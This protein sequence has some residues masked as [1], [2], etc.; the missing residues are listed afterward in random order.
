MSVISVSGTD[1]RAPTPTALR[2][3][4]SWDGLLATEALP[5]LQNVPPRIKG[6]VPLRLQAFSIFLA[7][8][9]SEQS[10][11]KMFVSVEAKVGEHL[12]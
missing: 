2:D 10:K 6:E 12:Y 1:L 9:S 5:A 4:Y 3:W 7:E 11:I 8:L